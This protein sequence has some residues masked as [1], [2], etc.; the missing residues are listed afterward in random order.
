MPVSEIAS[1]ERAD[2]HSEPTTDVPKHW[3]ELS[4]SISWCVLS[5]ECVCVVV[6]LGWEVAA[7]IASSGLVGAAAPWALLPPKLRSETGGGAD[8]CDR[9][10]AT[11]CEA[12]STAARGFFNF[13]LTISEFAIQS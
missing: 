5:A 1:P 11:T 8:G 12:Y 7:S 3:R 2:A 10:T 13:S 9:T 4:S 6:V